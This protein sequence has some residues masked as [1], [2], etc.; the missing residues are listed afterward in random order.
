MKLNL[1]VSNIRKHY[2]KFDYIL[3]ELINED[4]DIQ[5]N[6]VKLTPQ[7]DALIQ[8]LESHRFLNLDHFYK[9][10]LHQFSD[11]LK[12]DKELEYKLKE[13][14]ASTFDTQFS[15]FIQNEYIVTHLDCSYQVDQFL[16]K[17]FYS[18]TNFKQY[19]DYLNAQHQIKVYA[20]QDDIPLKDYKKYNTRR[21][22]TLYGFKSQLKQQNVFEKKVVRHENDVAMHNVFI[23]YYIPIIKQW[24]EQHLYTYVEVRRGHQIIDLYG[25]HQLVTKAEEILMKEYTALNY[26]CGILKFKDL[27]DE[28]IQLMQIQEVLNQNQYYDYE[29]AKHSSF[30]LDQLENSLKSV[31]CR[32]FSAI[33]VIDFRNAKLCNNAKY[34]FNFN[35]DRKNI[36]IILENEVYK[37]SKTHR[38]GKAL[39]YFVIING[40][41]QQSVFLKKLNDDLD[42]IHQNIHNINQT[43]YLRNLSEKELNNLLNT[44]QVKLKF[45]QNCIDVLGKQQQVDRFLQFLIKQISPQADVIDFHYFRNQFNYNVIINNYKDTL[46]DMLQQC[47]CQSSFEEKSMIM[48]IFSRDSSKILQLKTQ[49]RLLEN[50]IEKSK[51]TIQIQI[52]KP[53]NIHLHSL[54]QQISSKF[55]SVVITI[56]KNN[57]SGLKQ[58][59]SF[60]KKQS[61]I[62][63]FYGQPNL[64]YDI[65]KDSLNLKNSMILIPTEKIHDQPQTT[66]LLWL[67]EL[68]Q[69]NNITLINQKE[70]SSFELFQYE[71]NFQQKLTDSDSIQKYVYETVED[72]LKPQNYIHYF[73]KQSLH[74][75]YDKLIDEIKTSNPT[76]III[77][78][79]VQKNCQDLR[80]LIEYIKQADFPSIQISLMTDEKNDLTALKSFLNENFEEEYSN[81]D[82][83][84]YHI[85]IKGCFQE[86]LNQVIKELNEI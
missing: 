49:L 81:Q 78:S 11:I 25:P 59:S 64:L 51:K 68:I 7:T 21:T 73:D 1:Q 23:E 74:K 48:K 15:W 34:Y 57:D 18:Q 16:N 71:L 12:Y 4:V 56:E 17:L 50:D 47:Q 37:L 14:V 10:P 9:I 62:K 65:Q 22:Y 29:V 54:I 77:T 44:Y 55:P 40:R 80:Q 8:K 43:N 60:T 76:S 63:V 6:V 72:L 61:K 69:Q 75:S 38:D 46:Q 85:S 13:F 84:T 26:Q 45:N 2:D 33:L 86:T 83:Q 20:S 31:K 42:I 79:L 41:F 70:N 32:I 39:S 36:E 3:Q 58:L 35:Q 52:E 24:I 30:A 66:Q 19:A 5:I 67:N 27:D 82:K 53:L 28:S